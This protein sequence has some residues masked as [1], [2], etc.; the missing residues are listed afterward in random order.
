[1][2]KLKLGGDESDPHLSSLNNFTRRQAWEFD[3]DAGT[4]EERAE[5]EAARQNFYD[6]RFKVRPD[7][8]LLW[9][10]QNLQA[11][12]VGALMS[13]STMM[14]ISL[15]PREFNAATQVTNTFRILV[16]NRGHS[17]VYES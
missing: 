7:S 12:T 16:H 9:R 11:F 10:F 2:W 1:M 15:W 4:P 3:P 13:P 14:A 6:N 5:I 17:T 8:D